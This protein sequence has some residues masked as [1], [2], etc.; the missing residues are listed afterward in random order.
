MKKGK[1]EAGKFSAGW[2]MLVLLL[3]FVTAFAAVRPKQPVP[4]S[5]ADQECF[6]NDQGGKLPGFL[7]DLMNGFVQSGIN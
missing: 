1:T 6:A 7:P 3:L 5:D 2:L 4:A